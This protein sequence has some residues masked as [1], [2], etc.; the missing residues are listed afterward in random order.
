MFLAGPQWALR[1]KQFNPTFKHRVL[2]GHLPTINAKTKALVTLL[3]TFVGQGAKDVLPHL[4]RWSFGVAT[5][6]F[7]KGLYFSYNLLMISCL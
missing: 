1:R 7:L 3:D 2:L 6:M 5:R 4:F